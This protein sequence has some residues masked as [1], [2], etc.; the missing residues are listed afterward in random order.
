MNVMTFR[1]FS[2]S[3]YYTLNCTVR[4]VKA[5][6]PSQTLKD[7]NKVDKVKI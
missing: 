6:Q 3:K 1:S 2:F 4:N 5:Q 7:Y